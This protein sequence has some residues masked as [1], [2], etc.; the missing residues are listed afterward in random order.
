MKK[1]ITIISII[2]FTIPLISFAA[3]FSNLT[4]LIRLLIEIINQ[5]IAVVA[6]LALL[7]F[8]WGLAN[9]IL[10]SSNEEKKGEGKN[11]MIWGI[12]ALFIMFSVW[13]L[14]GVLQNTFLRGS[15]TGSKSLP[16]LPSLS[17]SGLNQLS[18]GPD[19][20]GY[21]IDKPPSSS[22]LLKDINQKSK[23]N[24]NLKSLPSLSPSSLD[25]LSR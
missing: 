19:S 4:G 24:T 14:I 18:P 2:L 11:I 25:Q 7:F 10:N 17:P 3:L 16:S 22:D 15:S 1:N 13:G 9:F 21:I 8:F 5:A 20:S 23:N 6:S 12:V